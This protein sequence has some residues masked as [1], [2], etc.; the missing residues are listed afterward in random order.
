MAQRTFAKQIAAELTPANYTPG[1]SPGVE[2]QLEGIDAELGAADRAIAY[3]TTLQAIAVVN[4]WQDLTFNTNVDLAGWAHTAGSALFTAPVA[5]LF[6]ATCQLHMEQTGG[7]TNPFAMRFLFN[8]VEVAGSF[9]SKAISTNS[10]T[11][12]LDQTFPFTAV[13]TQDF[14]VQIAGANTNMRT[15]LG[16]VA[17]APTTNVSANLVIRK[18]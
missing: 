7:G 10:I 18:F 9:R 13:A 17:A 6:I 5:G 4:T 11:W 3:D 1:S 12:I 2:G 14:K 16:G 8:G 15:R